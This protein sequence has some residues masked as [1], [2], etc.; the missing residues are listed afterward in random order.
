[1]YHCTLWLAL[2]EIGF[3]HVGHFSV[4]GVSEDLLKEMGVRLIAIDRPGYG[5]STPN[6]NQTFKTAAADIANIADILEMGEKIYIL[7][8]SCGGAYT[9]GAARYIP[10]RIA[11]IA[12]WAP[13]G[14]Y[15]WKV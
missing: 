15:W 8:Y 13:V 5:L 14:S 6:P 4:P 2:R 10:E 11:G 7:G 12:M 1:V 9:W 3:A